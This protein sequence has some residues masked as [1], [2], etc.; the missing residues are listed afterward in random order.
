MQL[1][2]PL[3]GQAKHLAR[4]RQ[5]GQLSRLRHQ[6]CRQLAQARLCQQMLTIVEHKQQPARGQVA[7]QLRLKIASSVNGQPWHFVLVPRAD[8][9]P[10]GRVL[11]SLHAGNVVWARHPP[12]LLLA[13]A[14]MRW[15]D[16]APNRTALYDLGQAVAHLSVQAAALWLWVHQIGGFDH[17]QAREAFVI[18][19]GYDPVT[20]I[21]IGEMGDHE[22]LPEPLHER[23]QAPRTRQPLVVFVFGDVWGSPAPLLSAVAE[24]SGLEQPISIVRTDSDQPK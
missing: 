13:A 11:Q 4:G 1:H 2:D 9:G 14:Q 17:R 16:G 5:D 19:E 23:E 21:A 24:M 7:N 15:D 12:L 10:F 22:T 18:P 3:A 8:S 20:W 6:R